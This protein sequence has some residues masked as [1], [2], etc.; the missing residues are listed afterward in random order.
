MPIL[1][2]RHL[3][4]RRR[5]KPKGPAVVAC[6]SC[7]QVAAAKFCSVR[8]EEEAAARAAAIANGEVLEDAEPEAV[9]DCCKG[10]AYA[11]C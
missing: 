5:Q 10:M 7:S 11:A 1:M 9:E 4:K 8:R 6:G 2:R 3:R